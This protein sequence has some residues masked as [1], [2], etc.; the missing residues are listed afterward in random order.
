[1]SVLAVQHG[2]SHYQ[3]RGIQPIQY[4]VANKL[5]FMQGNALKYITRHKDKNGAE[6]IKKAIHYLQMILEFDYG[7]ESKF[8][9]IEKV[10][11]GGGITVPVTGMPLSGRQVSTTPSAVVQGS[12]VK[13]EG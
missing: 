3:D 11:P 10:L 1:M 12:S 4:I 9:V 5:D 6:D 8:E 7:V 13:Y 2:G